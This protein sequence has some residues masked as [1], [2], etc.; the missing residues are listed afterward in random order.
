[1]KMFS[2]IDPLEIVRALELML[3]P[4]QVVELRALDA[5]TQRDWRPHTESGYFTDISILVKAV[6]RIESAKGIYFTPN[7]ID[8]ALLARAMNRARAV[9]GE[10]TTSDHDTTERRWLLVDVDPVRASGISSSDAEHEA[11]MKAVRNIAEAF[12]RRLARSDCRRQWQW[13][14]S[15]LS[16]RLAG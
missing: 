13:C 6:E 9:R 8:A 16:N 11:A 7:P 14:S 1:M 12:R 10:P 5:V 15:P 2:R 4:G 3:A